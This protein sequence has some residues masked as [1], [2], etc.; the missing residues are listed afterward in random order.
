M[1][2]CTAVRLRNPPLK[3]NIICWIEWALIIGACKHICGVHTSLV[4]FVKYN[5]IAAD[6]VTAVVVAATDIYTIIKMGNLE[7]TETNF[8]R[9]PN[10]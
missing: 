2:S 4:L 1:R 10:K 7:K 6:T 3:I 8:Q 5:T 9:F